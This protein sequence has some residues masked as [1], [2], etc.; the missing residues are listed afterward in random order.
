MSKNISVLL[1]LV[2]FSFKGKAQNDATFKP[3][4][5]I[6]GRI[7]Y[8]FE[9]LKAGEESLNGNEFRRVRLNAKGK[10]NKTINYKVEFDFAKGKVNFRDVYLQLNL[11]NKYGN[12]LI[13]S[14]T[15]PSSL[16]NMT[17]SKYITFF[18][19]AMLSNTQ[20]FKYNAGIMYNNQKIL[21]GN[22]GLQLAYTF[23]GATEP[24]FTDKALEG[25]ANIIARITTAFLKNKEK[26]TLVHIGVNY[27][28]RDNNIT[29]YNYAFKSENHLGHKIV[30][31][32]KLKENDLGVLVNVADIKTDGIFKSTNDIGLELATTIGALSIQGE[33]ELSSIK[34]DVNN[35]N[36]K[37]YYAFA[38]YFLT[39]EHRP[40]KNSSFTRVKPKKEFLKNGGFGAVELAFRYS[41]MDYS[42][43]PNTTINN[44]IANITA[45]VN[46]YLNKNTRI[47]YNYV[48]TNYNEVLIY[49]NNNLKGHLI[50]FQVDF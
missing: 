50:R 32:E 28:H 8:D 47:M 45:G 13:G 37:A 34:T 21:N 19:R 23:N 39:G 15:E 31:G 24:A 4:L 7:M 46:W 6:E 20:P 16:N 10:V 17:S 42:D 36:A 27:E 11:P 29:S 40:Y 5:K 44:K 48:S 43:Y 41:V 26:N 25:G 22:L 2:F 33:Y 1:V 38:S 9:F 12:I 30:I 3:S 18:E 14:F 49:G 35:Y